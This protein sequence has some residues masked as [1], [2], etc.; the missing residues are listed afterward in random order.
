MI[1][2]CTALVASLDV[3]GTGLLLSGRR[4]ALSGALFGLTPYV[5]C[6][7]ILSHWISWDGCFAMWSQ[8]ARGQWSGSF[9][10]PGWYQHDEDVTKIR[11]RK[12]LQ[13][14]YSEMCS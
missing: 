13:S 1:D 4:T 10:S 8:R 7:S 2:V 12:Y 5:S 6:I 14:V 11:S 3:G 9:F